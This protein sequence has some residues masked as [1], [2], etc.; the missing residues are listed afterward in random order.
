MNFFKKDINTYKRYWYVQNVKTRQSPTT[1]K[2]QPLHILYGNEEPATKA[3]STIQCCTSFL[4]AWLTDLASYAH[5]H[6]FFSFSQ[7][8]QSQ[9]Q[10]M[11][12]DKAGSRGQWCEKEAMSQ[13]RKRK[14]IAYPRKSSEAMRPC[15]HFDL[16]TS[17]LQ[18]RPII[19]FMLFT[20]CGD[21][22]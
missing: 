3:Y 10:R 15:H 21:F 1:R 2:R 22:L 12:G 9:I 16:R 4:T 8:S 18:V 6:L 13:A 5:F 11:R 17:D 7:E 19:N 20:F 14:E